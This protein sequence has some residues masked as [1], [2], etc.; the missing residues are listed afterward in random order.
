MIKHNPDIVYPNFT[1]LVEFYFDDPE[2]I[3]IWG[4]YKIDDREIISLEDGSILSIDEFDLVIHKAY[5]MSELKHVLTIWRDHQKV[6]W[7]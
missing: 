3:F 4:I 2:V 5:P 1:C 6:P 7:D